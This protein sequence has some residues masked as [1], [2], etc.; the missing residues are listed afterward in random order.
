MFGNSVYN[1]CYSDGGDVTNIQVPVMMNDVGTSRAENGHGS[2]HH[3]LETVDREGGEGGDEAATEVLSEED[4]GDRSTVTGG[5]DENDDNKVNLV[6]EH[7]VAEH[8]SPVE[9]VRSGELSQIC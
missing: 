2:S 8:I 6:E 5:D 1:N 3:G 9:G 4:G 7:T